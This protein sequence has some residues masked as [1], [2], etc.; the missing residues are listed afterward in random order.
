MKPTTNAQNY[1]FIFRAPGVGLIRR[2]HVTRAGDAEN[3]ARKMARIAVK[4]TGAETVV[5]VYKGP[6]ERDLPPKLAEEIER[7]GTV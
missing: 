6:V 2:T 1:V 5:C 4:E 3:A 7:E